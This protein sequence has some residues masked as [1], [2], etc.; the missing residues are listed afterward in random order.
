MSS[1][2]AI[3]VCMYLVF[4][5]G[6][7]IEGFSRRKSMSKRYVRSVVNFQKE[8]ASYVAWGLAFIIGAI[9]YLTSGV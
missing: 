2:V 4:K 9:A 8:Q 7:W 6:S 5:A 3:S 1:I